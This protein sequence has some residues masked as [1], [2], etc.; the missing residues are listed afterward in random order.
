MLLGRSLAMK[1]ESSMFWY[2]PNGNAFQLNPNV[3]QAY[4]YST[5][6]YPQ[7]RYNRQQSVRGQA[8]WTNGG[9]ITK[10][11]IP[12]S[13]NEYMTAAVGVN[14]PYKCGQPL[15]VRNL[16]TPGAREIIVTVVDQVA[17]YSPH[18]INLHRRA[19]EALGAPLDVGILPV[20]IIPSPELEQ[21]KWGKYLLEVAQT[22]YPG[23]NVIEYKSIGK[24]QISP[25][26]TREIY[27]FI[28]QSPQEKMTIQGTVHYNPETDRILS[29]NLKEV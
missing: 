8:T 2:Y 19:F 13:K 18:N 25:Q 22:A 10:C 11:G 1:G 7:Y 28:L 27:E 15:K 21:E 6:V 17:D 4:F 9:T 3:Q 5:N 12:W 29:F 24:K 26:Q 20:E 23:F 16:S 14:S